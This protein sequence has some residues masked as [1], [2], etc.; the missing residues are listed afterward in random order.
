VSGADQQR[1]F[2]QEVGVHGARS[3]N[4]EDALV[5]LTDINANTN[6]DTVPLEVWDDVRERMAASGVSHRALASGL[7]MQYCGSALFK[8]AMSRSRLSK[9]A[10]IL[11]D[12]EFLT[13]ADSDVLWDEIKSIEPD[14]EEEVFDARVPG[15]HNFVAD[16]LIVHNSGAIEQDAD[17]VLFIYRDEYY[18]PT[19]GRP[20]SAE[21][22]IAKHR[23]G[24]T[25]MVELNFQGEFTRFANM[26]PDVPVA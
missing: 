16:D 23:Q 26:G 14:G 19:E 21:V 25:G 6:V 22:I 4:V 18:S 2:L 15:L 8:S 12:D 24:S 9:V 11:D 7:E 20:G 17:V 13:L 3:R 10:T 1:R 5:A